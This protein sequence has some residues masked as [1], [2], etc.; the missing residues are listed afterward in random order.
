[1]AETIKFTLKTLRLPNKNPEI[2]FCGKHMILDQDE[3]ELLYDA[4][5]GSN[6]VTIKFLNKSNRDT[7]VVDGNIVADLA[8]IVDKIEYRAQNLHSY[9]E[10]ISEYIDD[11]NRLIQGA[12]GFMAF[13]GTL[14]IQ[15]EGPVFVY[16]RDL[17]IKNG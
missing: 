15:I 9:I 1:L 17:A 8:V 7:K 12:Y 14:T 3:V 2:L 10:S 6:K 5:L 4:K 13:N 16:L 11:N